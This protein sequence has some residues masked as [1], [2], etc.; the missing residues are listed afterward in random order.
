MGFWEVKRTREA[1]EYQP[2][3]LWKADLHEVVQNSRKEPHRSFETWGCDKVQRTVGAIHTSQHPKKAPS[4]IHVDVCSL[5]LKHFLHDIFPFTGNPTLRS[6]RAADSL[7]FE[8]WMNFEAPSCSDCQTLQRTT[9]VPRHLSPVRLLALPFKV[10]RSDISSVNLD[11]PS[12]ATPLC[13]SL[14]SPW[15]RDNHAIILAMRCKYARTRTR[16]HAE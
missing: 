11:L 4:S 12:A 3:D 7:L 9:A 6:A 16:T 1:A 15:G 8:T 13:L 5:L 10:L 2:V 14:R